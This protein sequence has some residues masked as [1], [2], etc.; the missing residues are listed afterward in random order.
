MVNDASLFSLH[1]CITVIG[2]VGNRDKAEMA[3]SNGCDHPVLFW[4]KGVP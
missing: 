4:P 2:T 3:K 1:A